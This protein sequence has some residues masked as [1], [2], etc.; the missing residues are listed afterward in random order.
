MATG[1]VH[2]HTVAAVTTAL[3]VAAVRS[4]VAMTDG[5][6]V[7]VLSGLGGAGKS[8]AAQALEDLGFFVVDNLSP[9]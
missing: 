7:I 9:H 4:E 5:K 6:Q 1:S 3:L 8:P 2:V